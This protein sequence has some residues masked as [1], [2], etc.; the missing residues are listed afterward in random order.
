MRVLIL[1]LAA[2]GH[3]SPDNPLGFNDIGARVMSEGFGVLTPLIQEMR[4][5]FDVLMLRSPTGVTRDDELEPKRHLYSVRNEIV[6]PMGYFVLER[7][8][9]AAVASF[10]EF[11]HEL[12]QRKLS[13]GIWL[14][15]STARD[16]G[17][18]RKWMTWATMHKH[19]ADIYQ[20]AW[21]GFQVI[22]LDAPN[23]VV[24]KGG[25]NPLLLREYLA[26]VREAPAAVYAEGHDTRVVGHGISNKR[27]L[28]QVDEWTD[29]LLI[30]N[31]QFDAMPDP[32][33]RRWAIAYHNAI[34]LDMVSRL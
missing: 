19:V 2:Q 3:R 12:A 8:S 26:Q 14:G 17:N 15:L 24:G 9:H 4:G 23:W 22:G 20:L 5:T 32:L 33:P 34:K 7:W 30:L 11:K 27:P 16:N 6:D 29:D 21:M 1:P 18:R 13:L 10:S 31:G 25:Q 28:T